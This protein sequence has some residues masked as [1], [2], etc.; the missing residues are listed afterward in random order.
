MRVLVY[1]LLFLLLAII[2]GIYLSRESGQVV[3]AFSDYTVQTSLAFF[4]LLLVIAFLI[5]HILLRALSAL[6]NLP[7]NMRRWKKTRAHSRSEHYLSRGFMALTEGDWREA[8]KLLRK[9][10]AYSRLPVVNYI[11]AA[12]AAQQLGAV[13][14]RDHYLRLA[15]NEDAGSAYA[16]DVTRAELQLNQQQTEQAYA[17][18][19]HIDSDRPG[20][21]RVKLML[22]EASSQLKDWQ[23]SLSLLQDLESKGAMPVEKVRSKQLRAYANILD[24]ASRTGNVADLVEAWERIPKKLKKELYLIE[25]YV[26]GRLRYPDTADCEPLLRQVIKVRPDPAL[27]RLYGLVQAPDQNKQLAFVEKLLSENSNDWVMLLTAGRLYKRGE[28]WGKS[29]S[30][31]EKSLEIEPSAEAYYELAT[32]LENQGQDEA[33]RT[34]YQKGL[35]HAAEVRQSTALVLSEPT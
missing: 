35:A 4:I 25:V 2:A 31:L 24:A 5:F 18:L 9:G 34:C 15:Y 33:A 7:E 22:L 19:K 8:E 11:G 16:V 32:L 30:A 14:R 1:S 12:R 13:D 29:K 6:L 28:L 23:Q 26:S 17:T 10:A 21:N 20:Q 3:L 27:V